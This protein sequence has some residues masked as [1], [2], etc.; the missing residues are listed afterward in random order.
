MRSAAFAGSFE[1]KSDVV[2]Q[3]LKQALAPVE[4]LEC[5]HPE[6]TDDIVKAGFVKAQNRRYSLQ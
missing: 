3:R 1:L 5:L 6:I 2:L 4:E